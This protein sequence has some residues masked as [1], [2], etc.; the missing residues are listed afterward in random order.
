MVIAFTILVIIIPCMLS[1][2]FPASKVLFFFHCLLLSIWIGLY[3]GDIDLIWYRMEYAEQFISTTIAERLYDYLAILAYKLGCPFPVFHFLISALAIAI[4]AYVVYKNTKHPALC[5]TFLWGFLTFE[6]AW[7]IRML[8]ASA[9]ILYAVLNYLNTRNRLQYS[10]LILL[11]TGFHFSSVFFFV[12]LVFERFSVKTF[13]QI[14]FF[15][16]LIGTLLVPMMMALLSSLVPAI[17][18]YTS[19]LSILTVVCSVVW[20]AGCL[21]VSYL[22]C[23]MYDY[24]F[25]ND[26]RSCKPISLIKSKASYVFF[27]NMAI[28]LVV[29]FFWYTNVVAVRFVRMGFFLVSLLACDLSINHKSHS[30]I[31]VLFFSMYMAVSLLLFFVVFHPTSGH[32]LIEFLTENYFVRAVT[33]S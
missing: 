24:S 14:L 9:I 7:Q 33:G 10:I 8:C 21:F 18:A 31:V 2:A 23:D 5:M 26:V 4:Y 28:C 25:R 32:I 1:I 13:S 16:I 15:E 3:C 27:F 12:L 20:Q 6:Y 29:P 17:G 19:K 11:A 30:S 22:V